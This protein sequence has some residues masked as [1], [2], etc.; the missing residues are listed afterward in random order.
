M[1]EV[2][3]SVRPPVSAWLLALLLLLLWLLFILITNIFLNANMANKMEMRNACTHMSCQLETHKIFY[4]FVSVFMRNTQIQQQRNQHEP[5]QKLNTQAGQKARRILLIRGGESQNGGERTRVPSA[6]RSKVSRRSP[7]QV[8]AGYYN[9]IDD[10]TDPSLD[11]S[12]ISALTPKS[13]RRKSQLQ[14]DLNER[15]NF[16]DL[17][18]L[19]L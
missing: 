6:V 12:Q 1:T 17:S 14:L 4:F 16:Y 8:I 7:V 19:L 18:P 2:Y 13:E 11:C 5:S 10:W 15:C 3:R 9:G